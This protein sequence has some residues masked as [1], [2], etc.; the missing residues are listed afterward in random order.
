MF[1]KAVLKYVLD[2]NI[3]NV[4]FCLLVGA[5]S[6]VFWSAV[7]FSTVGIFV[8]YLGFKTF[9]KNEYYTYYNLGYTKKHLLKRVLLLNFFISV[10]II[11]TYQLFL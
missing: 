5:F 10:F 1:N 11:L 8:G 6:S 3:F 2:V 4:V 9:K 7:L